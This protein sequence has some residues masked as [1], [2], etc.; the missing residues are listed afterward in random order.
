MF[1]DVAGTRI[2]NERASKIGGIPDI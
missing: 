2:L 1:A